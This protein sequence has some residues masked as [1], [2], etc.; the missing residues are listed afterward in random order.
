MALIQRT[1]TPASQ[2]GGSLGPTAK[3]DTNA[4]SDLAG[5][6]RIQVALGAF[7]Q[8]STVKAWGGTLGFRGV[9]VGAYVSFLTVPAGGTLA[10]NVIM[11]GASALTMATVNPEAA[12]TVVGYAMTLDATNKGTVHAATEVIEVDTVASDDVVGTAHVG[13]VLTL[14]VVP[15]EATTGPVFTDRS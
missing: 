4:L 7:T 11:Q 13:G 12:T 10:V 2:I 3:M 8:N 14:L 15:V 5:V 1:V 9:I 6:K